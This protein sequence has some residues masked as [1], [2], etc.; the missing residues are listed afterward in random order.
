MG[1][2]N[3][4]E[5]VRQSRA[6]R[7]TLPGRAARKA[8]PEKTVQTI[9]VEQAKNGE[10]LDFG[11]MLSEGEKTSTI[12]QRYAGVK[13]VIKAKESQ[14]KKADVPLDEQIEQLQTIRKSAIEYESFFVD[15]LVKQMRQSPLAQTP[16]GDTFS[17]IAEQPFR[18][19]L[20][21]AGG[22][23]L[24]D[25]IVQQVARQEGLEQTLHEHPGIMGPD[26]R[27]D[28]SANLVRKFTGP[29]GMAPENQ[30]FREKTAAEPASEAAEDSG[31][32]AV[33]SAKKS[34]SEPSAA[35]PVGLMNDEEIAW[36]YR[37]A[38]ESLA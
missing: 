37:D 24:A 4:L 32:A 12:R 15:H 23:G 8:Q 34:D 28:V 30:G 3:N 21:Q 5:A 20:S 31:R 10:T 25:S 36:L 16:G 19:F 14:D 2:I 38:A 13:P 18:D 35:R 17:D 6:S 29:L 9:S 26:W 11:A 22:F 33:G 7:K 27:P 1:E